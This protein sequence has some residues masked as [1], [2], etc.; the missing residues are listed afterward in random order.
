MTRILIIEDDIAQNEMLVE[1]LQGEFEVYS[2][3]NGQD[4]VQLARQTMP[5]LI[6]CDINMPGMDG[7]AVLK[8][9]RSDPATADTTFVFATALSERHMLRQGMNAGADDYLTKPYSITELRKAIHVRLQKKAA[10]QNTVREQISTLRQ[11]IV[12][13]LPHEMRTAIMIVQGYTDLLMEDS[14]AA[15]RDDVWMLEALSQ[16]TGRLH[17]LA[18]KYLWFVRSQLLKASPPQDK[19]QTRME[20]LLHNAAFAEAE[21]CGRVSD[22]VVSAAPGIVAASDEF[23]HYAVRELIENACKFSEPGTPITVEAGVH[24]GYY[25]VVIRDSGRG[26]TGEQVNN[27]GA[28]MQFDRDTYEQQGTGLGLTIARQIIEGYRGSLA[29]YS[30]P[31]EGTE[32]VVMLPLAVS[33][34]MHEAHK[35]PV[36]ACASG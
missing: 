23:V 13:S 4:G 24:E 31:G 36:A 14:L 12:T 25:C 27:I 32:V 34:Y 15:G 30:A 28:F 8:M 1:M 6:L 20:V 10:Q 35:D 11:N 21:V 17:Q 18:E 2:A 9:L 16:N 22:V 3:R 19:A 5:D 26:M 33:A 29:V 7:F